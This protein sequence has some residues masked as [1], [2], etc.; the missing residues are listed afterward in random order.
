MTPFCIKRLGI[1]AEVDLATS[2]L[3]DVCRCP[4]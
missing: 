3:V 4:K 1:I 2:R